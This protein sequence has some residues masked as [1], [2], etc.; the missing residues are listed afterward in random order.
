[1]CVGMKPAN[2][3]LYSKVK[4]EA[5][6]KFKA[7]PSAYASGW[8]VQEYKRQG[9]RYRGKGLK[10]WFKEEWETLDGKTC[11]RPKGSKRKY[12]RCR[13]TRRVSKDTPK[14]WKEMTPKERRE[15][16]KPR[17]ASRNV[18]RRRESSPAKARRG[19]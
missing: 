19:K 1:M 17:P 8:L 15:F 5:K 12:P 14:T 10:R 3:K 6:R 13:P 4:R 7:W 9:G 18:S 2:P 11:G 16:N